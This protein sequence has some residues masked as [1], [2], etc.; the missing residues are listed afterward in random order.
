M[1]FGFVKGKILCKNDGFLPSK[2]YIRNHEPKIPCIAAFWG[3]LTT[4]NSDKES[5]HVVGI[6][7]KAR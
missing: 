1:K 6:S 7:S 5:S 4:G 2:N 3:R